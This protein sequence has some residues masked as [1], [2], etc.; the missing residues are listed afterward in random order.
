[1]KVNYY[2][3]SGLSCL[4]GVID[5][6]VLF[7][8]YVYKSGTSQPYIEHCKEMYSDITNWVKIN[9]FDNV[10]DIGG[11][12]GTILLTFWKEEPKIWP[13]NVDP[14]KNITELSRMKKIETHTEMWG[15]E[16][17]KKI[18]GDRK[19]KIIT[20]TNVFQHLE[21]IH[22]FVKGVYNSLFGISILEKKYGN[23]SI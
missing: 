9:E 23:I 18:L 12:D 20:S 8:H 4:S 19:A 10:V 11:N 6:D 17:A 13:I 15:T 16:S 14:S 5:P 22:D 1:M 3:D 7:S 2:A 21:N